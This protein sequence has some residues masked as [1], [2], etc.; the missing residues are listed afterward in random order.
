[1]KLSFS[2]YQ[3]TGNDFV[4]LDDRNRSFP[5]KDTAL[6]ARLCDRRFG[7]GADG[8]M[9]LQPH[10][11]LDFT[12][13]YY[14]ADGNP[15]TMCGNGGR[16]ISQFAK[17]LG[18]VSTEARFEAVDGPHDAHWQG[19]L[20]SLG[21]SNVSGIK[22]LSPSTFEVNTGSPHYIDIAH[23]YQ[24]PAFVSWA[25][26]IRNGEPYGQAGINVNIVTQ[27]DC[28]I[29]MRTYERGVEDE[30][31]SCGTGAVAAAL[32]AASIWQIGTPVQIA[33]PGGQLQVV[34]Q[35]NGEGFAQVRLIGPAQFVFRGEIEV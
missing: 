1:M 10:A 35:Q 27:T 11:T 23:D 5:M 32:V 16:C 33:T 34:F 2:K 25:K 31:Y 30:T 21:L 15:S 19:E 12:M 20:V 29:A 14:N 9:L 24:D 6:V 28:G 3:G 8:L 4:L 13:A 17:D 22:T 18:I 26:S 7:I